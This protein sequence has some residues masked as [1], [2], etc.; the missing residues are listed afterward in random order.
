MEFSRENIDPAQLAIFRALVEALLEEM[1]EA[2]RHGAFSQNIKERRDYSCALFDRPGDLVCGAAHIPV[3]LGSMDTAC[4]AALDEVGMNPGDAVI[5]NDPFSGGTHLPDITVIF[6]AFLSSEDE[7]DFLL[8]VRAHHAD[9]GGIAPG[10][11]PL[12]TEL[13][14]EGIVIPPS[15]VVRSGNVV[16][17][18]V[19]LISSH[20]RQPA[21]RSG[22]LRAQLA[23]GAV[24]LR[25][26]RELAASRGLE[27]IRAEAAALIEHS[28]KVLS[29][30]L[31]SM[32]TGVGE[33]F[34]EMDRI[35]DEPGAR[36]HCRVER[37]DG[38]MREL[39]FDFTH[40]SEQHPGCLN[41]TPAIVRSAVLYC[42]RLFLP[43]DTPTT[44][45][46]LK[47]VK[48]RLMKGSVLD[49]HPGAAVAGGNVETSQ[50]IVEA[51]LSAF[52]DLGWNVPA[53]SQG[54]MNN[55]LL[56]GRMLDGDSEFSFYETIGGGAGASRASPGVSGIQTHMT[57]TRNTPVESLERAFPLRVR[58]YC[59]RRGSGGDG[60]NRGGDGI[61]RE[62]EILVPT[63][64]TILSGHR[65]SGPPGAEGGSAGSMGRN[66]LIRDGV[67]IELPARLMNDLK[68]GDILR[69][70]TP[71]GGGWG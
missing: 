32:E 66:L 45:G 15:Y 33:G 50:A 48:I 61:V 43:P 65:T 28:S 51:V 19:N 56:G 17:E 21:E 55:V 13:S 40:S 20:S 60:I 59:I 16:E 26:L 53:A 70:E 54:T 71:G 10:S 12:S 22:D 42:L 35:P 8:G 14:Q 23:S 24:G 68:P 30:F 11:L 44:S 63:R 25:R 3:H 2:L 47:P 38:G 18:T 67:E 37:I 52:G 4:K 62:Y 27:R 49:P 7:P 39:I 29:T 57:N 58:S 46:L 31:A 1:G 64:C 34:A 69:I 6:P 41:A 9:V 36:I 5:L